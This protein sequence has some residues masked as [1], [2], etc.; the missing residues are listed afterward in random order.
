[1]F[2]FCVLRLFRVTDDLQE[3]FVSW[4][5]ADVFGWPCT[6]TIG[7]GWML[8]GVIEKKQVFKTDRM[9]PV[10]S[11]IINVREPRAYVG[12][13]PQ[14]DFVLVEDPRIF[15]E[16]I[17]LKSGDVIVAQ[18]TANSLVSEQRRSRLYHPLDHTHWQYK[19][20]RVRQQHEAIA[21]VEGCGALID[22]IRHHH[23]CAD[24]G[25]ARRRAANRVGDQHGAKALSLPCFGD[26]Q[27]P[28]QDRGHQRIARDL[29]PVCLAAYTRRAAVKA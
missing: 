18:A 19:T 22:R 9:M 23:R 5:A 28:D 20:Q 10:V 6:G 8:G 16:S 4:N 21:F 3:L 7:T 17:V 29:F 11:K 15:L 27:T 14:V 2:Y 1:M 25:G 12:E 24:R 13:V 26:R